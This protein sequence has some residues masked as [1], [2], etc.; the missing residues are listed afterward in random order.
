MTRTFKRGEYVSYEEL[1]IEA[2]NAGLTVKEKPLLLSDGRIKGQRIAIR[3][4]IRTQRQKAD[5]L[6]EELGHFYTTSGD[7]MAQSSVSDQKQEYTA[8]LWAFDRQVGLSGIIC[9]YRNHCYN[10]HELA[11]CLDVSEEFLKE[12]LECYRAKYGCYTELD[13]YT[14]M[15]EPHLAVMEIL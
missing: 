12:A 11:E 9:G 1:L 10:L 6:A 15:F 8:R 5:V 3:K 13:G 14:I 2:D 7:I 4:D